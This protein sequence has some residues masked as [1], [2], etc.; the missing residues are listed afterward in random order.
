MKCKRCESTDIQTGAAEEGVFFRCRNC[1]FYWIL[2]IAEFDLPEV[3]QNVMADA[4]RETLLRLAGQILASSIR[5]KND[6]YY[7]REHL[8]RSVRFKKAKEVAERFIDWFDE[9]EKS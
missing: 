2:D 6:L 7:L 3:I 5:D 9:Q 1:G 8:D 4:R